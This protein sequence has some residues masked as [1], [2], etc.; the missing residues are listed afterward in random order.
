MEMAIT[1]DPMVEQ[2]LIIGEGKPYLSVIVVLESETWKVEA[3]TQGFDVSDPSVLNSKPVCK[4]ILE[5]IAP[6]LKN[7]PGYAKVRAVT[8]LDTPWNIDDGTMTPTMKLRRTIIMEKN[9]HDIE[10]MYKGH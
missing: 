9:K 5:R 4:W 8:L 2:A 1:L 3:G 10:K 7:F 6:Q